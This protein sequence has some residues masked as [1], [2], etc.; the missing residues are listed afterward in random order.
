MIFVVLTVRNQ[1]VRLASLLPHLEEVDMPLFVIVVDDDSQDGTAD[2]AEHYP[3]LRGRLRLVQHVRRH[4][5]GRC[6]VAGLREALALRRNPGDLVVTLPVGDPVPGG[7]D[8]EGPEIELLVR[9]IRRLEEGMDLV[10]GSRF[11]PGGGEPGLSRWKRF[12]SRGLAGLLHVLFPLAG[13]RDYTS[14]YRGMRL[15]VVERAFAVHGRNLV[16]CSGEPG[17]AELLVRLGRMGVRAA[18]VPL[19]LEPGLPR[20][21]RRRFGLR[22]LLGWLWMILV[23]LGPSRARASSRQ[24]RG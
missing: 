19:W 11:I 18:E 13:V 20:M 15:A 22:S 10:V 24:A 23:L 17:P 6:V 21:D 12:L 14:G 3:G 2:V 9:I 1:S 8:A 5:E 16:T 4:G 7:G